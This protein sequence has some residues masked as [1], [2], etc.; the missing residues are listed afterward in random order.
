[1]ATEIVLPNEWQP[2]SYQR[3]LWLALEGGVKRACAVWHRRA[4][5]D[6]TLF[7]Y[8]AVASQKRVGVYWHCSPSY[9]QGRKI[10]WEGIRGDGKR[11]LDAFPGW[12]TPGPG[13]FVTRVRDDEMTLW[14]ANGSVIQVVGTDNVD[15]L[16]GTN[17]V[18]I[19]MTEY[20]MVGAYA[21]TFTFD[22]ATARRR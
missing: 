13:Q 4:G 2:R 1:M 5:K 21:A 15:T 17:P 14:L 6:L 22:T 7:N 11:Y 3:P 9:K 19:A 12:R 10:I 20:A 18:F 8:I 16:V